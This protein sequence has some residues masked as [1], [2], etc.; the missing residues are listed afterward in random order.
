M[1]LLFLADE[2]PDMIYICLNKDILYIIKNFNV[3]EKKFLTSDE[4]CGRIYR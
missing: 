1:S 4:I 2:Q 3:L